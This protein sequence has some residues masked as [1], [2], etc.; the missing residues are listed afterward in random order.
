[1]KFWNLSI[2]SIHSPTEEEK[3]Q[4]YVLLE[5]ELDKASSNDVKLITGDFNGEIGR[6]ESSQYLVSIAYCRKQITMG[7]KQS[8]LLSAMVCEYE[9][10]HS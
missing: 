8:N 2:F 1:M 5:S 6:K 7:R 4:F 10:P 9:A 3:E